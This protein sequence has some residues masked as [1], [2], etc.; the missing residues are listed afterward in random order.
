MTTMREK[1][2]RAIEPVAWAD[3]WDKYFWAEDERDSFRVR[4]I[5]NATA[6]LHALRD[7][8]ADPVV[9]KAIQLAIEEE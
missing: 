1:I 4:A 3:D 2:A 5:E 9:R 6:A 8:F 7:E